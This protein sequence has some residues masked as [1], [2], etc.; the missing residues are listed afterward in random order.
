MLPTSGND[1]NLVH[2]VASYC[3][4]CRWHIDVIVSAKDQAGRQELCG[5]QNTEYPLHHFVFDGD[6][7][8]ESNGIGSQQ[9]PKSFKFHCTS[10]TCATSVQMDLKPPRFT[11]HD[12]QL[13]M[14]KAGLRKRFQDAQGLIG[15]RE[16]ETMSRPVDGPDFLDTF[17]KDSLN[18][19]PG[20]T[21]VP[22]LNRKFAKTFWRD[23]DSILKKLGFQFVIE[24]S[25]KEGEE[26][27]EAW[28]LPKPEAHQDPFEPNLRTIIEDARFELNSMIQAVPEPER[29]SIRQQ[30]MYPVPSQGDIERILACHDC[31]CA[32]IWSLLNC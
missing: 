28:Y 30:P 22:M 24:E 5:R 19:V 6:G 17:L 14:N 3:T 32:R 25:E 29:Q 15:E 11:E 8:G 12:Q 4:Q 2:K 9:A 26:S 13:L 7:K 20:K 18:P 1:D 23:C 21:R 10:P 16:G 27:V 31:K